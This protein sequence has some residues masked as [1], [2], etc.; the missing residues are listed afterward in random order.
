LVGCDQE[1]QYSR[2]HYAGEGDNV[3]QFFRDEYKDHKG[4]RKQ[5]T[6]RMRKLRRY[7]LT[8]YVLLILSLVQNGLT[9][10]IVVSYPGPYKVTLIIVLCVS[11][12]VSLPLLLSGIK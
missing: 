11:F 1:N 8:H 3:V 9:L 2:V 6:A 4:K 10:F 5:I 12:A 7:M